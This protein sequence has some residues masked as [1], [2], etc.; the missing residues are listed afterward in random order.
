M[1]FTEAIKI[2]LQSLWANKLRSIL[3]LLGVMI[4]V[5]AVI[6]VITLVNGANSFVATKVYG[7]GADV[8]TAAKQPT[9]VFSDAEYTRYQKRKDLTFDDYLDVAAKCKDC[10]ATGAMANTT[11]RVIYN[12]HSSKDT[13]VRG[14]TWSMPPIYGMNIDRGRGF[15]PI[16]EQRRN[17]VAIIGYDIVDNQIGQE[18]PIGKQIRVDGEQYTVIGVG[19]RKGKTLGQSQDNWVAIPLPTFLSVYG[20]NRSLT[21]YGRANGVG[22]AL[23]LAS[24]EVRTLLRVRRHDAPGADDSFSIDTN[25]TFIG[26][27]QSISSSFAAVFVSLA[28]IS[29]LVGGI[30]IMNI[31]LVSVT[32]RTR[33]IGLRKALGARRADV[34]LQF[35]IESATISLVG[36]LV[37]VVGGIVFAEIVT[38][39]VGFPSAI[40]LWSVFLALFAA[41]AVGVFF[42]V[43]PARKAARLDPITALRA[44]L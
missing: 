10:L 18:D 22:D 3:T 23:E 19:E 34:M 7:Y 30:V 31:M 33:E 44:E 26:L 11:G 32:E 37:G 21:L 15:T 36:G 28:A 41:T 5:A 6:M 40:R 43:Y 42:G 13:D 9:V 38:L 39:L 20:S 24:G 14:W 4:G 17:H 1:R 25:A 8:F 29:L 16:D 2:A 12:N 27:W 35:L